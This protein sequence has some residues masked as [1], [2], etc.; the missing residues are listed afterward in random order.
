MSTEDLQQFKQEFIQELE[1]KLPELSEVFQKYGLS[2]EAFQLE[3]NLTQIQASGEDF[4]DKK[5][6]MA[7]EA[8]DPIV[9]AKC[10]WGGGAKC[11]TASPTDL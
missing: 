6:V 3:V 7:F 11:I 2:P 10:G 4:R 1:K 9:I 8:K 5:P